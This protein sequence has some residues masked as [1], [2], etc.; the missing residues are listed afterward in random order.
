[1]PLA[2]FVARS[3]AYIA[4]MRAGGYHTVAFQERDA[5]F[6]LLLPGVGSAP[7]AAAAVQAVPC[8]LCEYDMPGAFAVC[9]GGGSD[10]KSHV[11]DV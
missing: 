9:S 8:Y 7:A 3:A 4:E 5:V 6:Y 1:M 10:D 2:R 11:V